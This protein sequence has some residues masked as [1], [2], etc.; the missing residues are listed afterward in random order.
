MSTVTDTEVN[1][2]IWTPTDSIDTDPSVLDRIATAKAKL[3]KRVLILGHHYQRDEVIA[4]ADRTGDSYGLSVHAANERDAEFVVFCGVHFMAETA[5]ILTDSH[6]A[7]ILPDLSAGCSMADMANFSQVKRAYRYITEV[8]GEEP[9]PLT[10]M[11]SSAEIK[12]FCGEHGGAVCTS[13]NAQAALKWAW[14][15]RRRI[16]FI[17]DEHLGRNTAYKLGVPLENMVVWDPLQPNGGVKNGAIDRAPIVLWRGYCSVHQRFIPAHID[18]FRTNY[19]N[20]NVIVHPECRYEVVQ[21]SDFAGS[22][23]YIIKMIERAAENEAGSLWAIGTEYHLVGRLQK[24]F[25]DCL[26]ISNLAFTTCNCAT[27]TRI[28]PIDLAEILEGLVQGK[29]TNQIRVSDSVKQ[30]SKVA[31]DRM[32]T[33]ATGS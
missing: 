24:R 13:S 23:D 27:M 22:T 10:Y 29:I 2:D 31:L 18:Y 19:P 14:Q 8:T 28:D 30:M 11:N 7:V 4:F 9:L 33:I 20:I 1:A 25:R 17:P 16:L 5:D 32:L 15:Q 12:A 3:G 21:Q 26:K 6:Q